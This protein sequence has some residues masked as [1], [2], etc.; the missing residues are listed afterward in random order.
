MVFSWIYQAGMVLLALSA[1][2]PGLTPKRDDEKASFLQFF[3][4]YSSL[5]IIAVGTGGIKPNVSAFGADQFD[6]RDPQECADKESFFNWFYLAVNV[7]SLI[8]SLVI[9]YIQENISWAIGFLIPG[10][11]MMLAVLVFMWGSAKYKHLPATESPISR[12][13]KVVYQA[14]ANRGK[15][16]PEVCGAER[17]CSIHCLRLL[18]W[19]VNL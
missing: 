11:C 3:C 4:L 5:Y 19:F 10:V 13:A 18:H 12:V 17:V 16:V 9:V 8:A 6:P 14:W 1:G 2:L 7:G 15:I